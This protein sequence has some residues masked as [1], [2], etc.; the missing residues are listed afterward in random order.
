[1]KRTLLVTALLVLSLAWLG[2]AAQEFVVGIE[3]STSGDWSNLIGSFESQTGISIQTIPFPQSSIAQQIVLQAFNRSGKLNFVMIPD[4]WASGLRN[5]VLDLSDV[6]DT[7][8]AQGVQLVTASDRP[9]G[10]PISFASGWFLAVMEWPSDQATALQWLVAVAE[11][12]S[13]TSSIPGTSQTATTVPGSTKISRSQHN[14]K[15][16]GSLESLLAV[17]QSA[18]SAASSNAMSALS[19]AAVTAMRNVASLFGIPLSSDGTSVTVV[20]ESSP[21]R[22][23]SA[24]VAALSA[25]GISRSAIEASSTLIKVSVPIGQLASLASQ[26][27]GVAFIRP[28]YTPY[29]LGTATQ[30]V[31]AIGA[32]AYLTA[33]ITG[34]GTK[35]AVIDLGFS[36]LTQAQARG[37]LPY[38]VV[39]N[40]LT[41]TGLTSGISH[42]TAVAEI[43]HDI[44]PDAQ[45]YLIKIGDEVDL[46]QA[47]TYCLSNGIDIINHSLGWYNTNFYDGT[48]TIADIA[49]RAISGGI[50]WVNAAGNEAQNH[51][52]GI[53]TDA[54]SDGWHDQTL[55][56]YA[57]SGS[58]IVLYLTWNEWPQS[59]TDYD[60][61]VYRPDG[62]LLASSTKL[63]TGTEEPTEAIQ[64]TASQSGTYSIRFQGSGSRTLEIYNLYQSLSPAVASS[65]ILAPANVAEVVSVGAVAYSSY[66]TG[67]QEP[68][69]S[70]GPTND[71]R[72]KPDLVCPDNVTTGTAPYTT[73][74]GTSGAAPHAAG[75]AALLLSSQPTLTESALR[76]LLLS[77]TIAMGSANVYGLGRLVLQAP[78]SGN[79][80]PIASFSYSPSSPTAGTTV[81]F[82]GGA[83]SDPDGS[84]VSY[85]WTFGDGATGS[86]V[87]AS[88]A[89][90]SA[91]SYTVR[92]TVTDNGGATGTTTQVVSVSSPANQNPV[93]SFSY[94]PS[95][96]TTGTTVN[97]YGGAS[98]DPDG[99]IVGYT[100]TFGDGAAGS[101]VNTSHAFTSAGSYT[102]RLTVTD[103]GGATG[104]TTQV[105]SVSAPTNQPPVASFTYSPS[106]PTPGSS[107][108]FNASGSYDPDG[109]L[110]S[111]GWTFGDGAIG[112]GVA[113]THA[114]SSSG[115]YSVTLTVRDNAGTTAVSTQQV[116]V[117][118][119]AAADLTVTS[120]AYSPSSP[121]IGQTV[122]FTFTVMNQGN[123]TA[124]G[125]RVTLQ[126]TA[127]S[128]NTYVTSLSVGA[129]R[130]L[131]LYLPLTASSE[132]FT[133][134]ADDLGQIPESNESNNTR[135]VTVSAGIPAPVA[136]AG[137][138]YSGTAG[139]PITL[140]GSGSS[141]SISSYTWT[142]GD[143]STATG[144]TPTHIYAAPGTYTAVLTVTGPGG[145]STD[146][147]TVTVGAAQPALVATLSLPKTTYQV[148]ETIAVTMTT[149]RSA[150]LYLCEVTA[151]N[152]VVLLYPNL[153]QQNPFV[154]P[155]SHVVPGGGYT[156]RVTT[157]TGTESLYL[158]AATG[159]ISGF[160]TSFGFGFPVLST[161]PT[162]FRTSALATMQAAFASG[163]WS[164]DSLAFNVISATPT[165]GTLRVLSTPTG[166]TVKLDGTS[167]GTT[168]LERSGVTPGT[169]TVQVSRS[170]YQS[171][172]QSVSITAGATSTVQVT[173]VA[174]PT[175][176]APTAV[177]TYSPTNPVVGDVVAFSAAGS[178]DPDGT[179]ISYA[180][181]FGDGSTGT[182]ASPSHEYLTNGTY[183][184][185]LTVT[186]NGGKTGSKSKD[187]SISLSDDVGW[188]SP[189]GYEDPSK[190]W[191]LPKNPY[192]ND[193][194]TRARYSLPAHS[195]SAYY[196]LLAP[197][198]G[199]LSDRIRIWVSDN[200]PGS[201]LLV[202][203]IDAE[204]D[205][206]WVNIYE[207]TPEKERAWLE[208]VFPAEGV[209]TQIRMRAENTSGGQWRAEIW[210]V[211]FKDATIPSP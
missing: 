62:T 94:S 124:G 159:P 207:G 59:S 80:N 89:F 103:N 125:F 145:S 193:T 78:T 81:S 84:I 25:L 8:T 39:Q 102:V 154:G 180:W 74:Q 162:S 142:F 144:I 172:T 130:T 30:G 196:F 56:F 36:G 186:D 203:S 45:L 169:H 52:E 189:V 67:P 6:A 75:A 55:S 171:V 208:I 88:H 68:Y 86:G 165:T 66:T 90:T 46:D 5:Y 91:G 98:S 73:F 65:S 178:S 112:S 134:V 119:A 174:I 118:V 192:D 96:P 99:S 170:G 211:D 195:W 179:V 92:L 13:S 181:N 188:I 146:T 72:T 120:L 173:L 150:Y 19:S 27:S 105:V 42:G 21:G 206:S 9:I 24:N 53:F 148:D 184:V 51:W 156:L 197:E 76:S 139:T 63:Q 131:T 147:A 190:N 141:G 128:T 41:G 38:S 109:S 32:D 1:M 48:G 23:S 163:D 69:S 18:A 115:T 113:T 137:G 158:F 114:Y 95:S 20:L 40:D 58:P 15:L 151:D 35:V 16:D 93:A 182:G 123:A 143:G 43:I 17:A 209:L 108:T 152:R 138:P 185:Q 57:A 29:A 28:P 33:G 127:S 26:L 111:Y 11:G 183:T 140:N 202:W 22:S 164:F 79:Q 149:N 204:V 54:N 117:Q 107:V 100:W 201:N 122:A 199:I 121:A 44:A 157:P 205:G 101:G 87:N 31:A 3:Q 82:Y 175:N 37:D 132:T 71:G 177:F 167:I 161:N 187:V 135:S 133:V 166:A 126:G 106:S 2:L 10:V 97:F 50:L 160:P 200:N 136:E 77:N 61:Y 210:E 198:G 12:L 49:R 85:A 110:V 191:V 153:Y 14:V 104:T 47:V 70:Q 176:Q 4:S 155:G 116:V 168:P 60:L 129:S 7:L 64:T 194:S 34:A 83:S